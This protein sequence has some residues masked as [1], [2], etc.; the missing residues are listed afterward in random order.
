MTETKIWS[1]GHVLFGEVFLNPQQ[2]K[3]LV[4]WLNL[5]GDEIRDKKH[6]PTIKNEEIRMVVNSVNGITMSA[7]DR[8][9]SLFNIEQL[10]QIKKFIN[11]HRDVV[12][13][14]EVI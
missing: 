2:I 4:N 8:Y 13:C 6:V 7:T 11:D 1:D 12:G 9:F 5:H 14:Q 3:Y 10:S